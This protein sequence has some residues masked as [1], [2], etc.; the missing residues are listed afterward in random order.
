MIKNLDDKEHSGYS[1]RSIVRTLKFFIDAIATIVLV[2][3]DVNLEIQFGY[4][5][6]L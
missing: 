4:C 2:M 3:F 6:K 1:K 5:Q